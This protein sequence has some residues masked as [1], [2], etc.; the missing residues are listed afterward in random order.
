MEHSIVGENKD[1]PFGR[2]L[3]RLTLALDD[4]D[5]LARL[6]DKPSGDMEVRGLSVVELELI[7][8]YLASDQ[9]WLRGWHAMAAQPYRSGTVSVEPLAPPFKRHQVSR[10]AQLWRPSMVVLPE[11]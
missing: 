3:Q 8:A 10:P 6:S 5:S 11:V 4:A 1:D 9:D 2:L 7:R